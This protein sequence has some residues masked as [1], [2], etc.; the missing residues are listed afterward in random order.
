LNG[1]V[2]ESDYERKFISNA[3]YDIKDRK[4]FPYLLKVSN[5]QIIDKS[6]SKDF[7]NIMNQNKEA[8]ILIQKINSFFQTS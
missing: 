5:G 4:G 8:E 2:P 6:I 1:Q 7:H 3:L